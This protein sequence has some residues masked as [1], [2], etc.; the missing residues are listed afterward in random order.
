[1][2]LVNLLETPEI[3]FQDET[4]VERA[5]FF[6]RS[7]KVDFAECMRLGCAVTNDRLPA[8]KIVDIGRSAE[9][10]RFGRP[11]LSSTCR[12]LSAI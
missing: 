7:R 8:P 6:Y 1:M 11:F 9:K 2:T 5:V 12:N 4:S 3:E 10:A